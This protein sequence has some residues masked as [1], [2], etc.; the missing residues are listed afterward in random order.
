M[1]AQI[2]IM[3]SRNEGAARLHLYQYEKGHTSYINTRSFLPAIEHYEQDCS[4]LIA[5]TGTIRRAHMLAFAS[6]S[7]IVR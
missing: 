2:V 4:L 5:T 6:V 7:F 3:S 1:S